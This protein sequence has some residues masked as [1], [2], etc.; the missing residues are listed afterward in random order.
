VLKAAVSDL[1]RLREIAGVLA[2]HGFDE[3]AVRVWGKAAP[4]QP[5]PAGA[6]PAAE[7]ASAVPPARR[8]RLV[9]Q[10]LG[11]TFIKLGQVLSARPDL[12]PRE[13]LEELAFLQDRVEPVPVAEVRATIEE[14]LGRPVEEL[15]AAF[16]DEPLAT[17]SIAQTHRATLSDGQ[18]VAVK[19]QRPDIAES[20]YSDLDLLR[21]LAHLLEAT[22]EEA[23][24]YD[25]VGIVEAFED[26]LTEELD[27]RLEIAHME[28]F[29]KSF[30][31]RRCL[32]IPAPLSELSCRTVITM[33][34]MDGV[35]VSAFGG[36]DHMGLASQLIEGFYRMVFDDGLFHADPHPGNLLVLEGDR[37]ALLDYGLVGRLTSEEQELLTLLGLGIFMKDVGGL[38]RLIFRIGAPEVHVSLS[39]FRQEIQVLLDRYVGVDLSDV[40]T[41][42]L[43]SELLDAAMRYGIRIPTQYA[44]LAKAGGTLEGVIRDLHPDLNPYQVA[45]PY[46]RE[47]MTRRFSPER[48]VGQLMR[49][50]LGLASFLQD[51]P[52]QLDQVLLDLE[53]G[54]LRVRMDNP[55][56]E[57]LGKNLN[58]LSTRL[59]FGCVAAGLIVAGALLVAPWQERLFEW[60]WVGL[61]ALA[62]AG[63]LVWMAAAWHVA[64]F[65][66]S[67]IRLR[68]WIAFWRRF[69]R[70][71][72]P[73]R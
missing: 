15:F 64:A 31:R 4:E 11:P 45:A 49:T 43:L 16:E 22:V 55:G 54:K 59:F 38:A 70:R 44:L 19:V 6:P 60:P 69:T 1:R 71:R 35:K 72:R 3:A 7:D 52:A 48:L 13:A 29:H 50:G 65:L 63:G 26:A 58:A 57:E 42:S 25:P 20:V 34:F 46:V 8:F 68:E 36:G 73:G 17:A 56:L 21:G 27:F 41:G 53:S 18:H 2:R 12:L 9:L 5:P 23:R 28:A 10:D 67:K 14:G 37:M 66:P 39:A 47:L 61:A 30:A 40:D 51:V 33:E 24:F 32:V 62:A